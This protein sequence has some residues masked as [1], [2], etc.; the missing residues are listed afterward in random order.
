M[1]NRLIGDIYI[2]ISMS[3]IHMYMPYLFPVILRII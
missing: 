2:A 1:V 3:H